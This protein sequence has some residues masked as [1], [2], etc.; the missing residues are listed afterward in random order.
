MER[1]FDRSFACSFLIFDHL[2]VP[3]TT[4]IDFKVQSFLFTFKIRYQYVI[5]IGFEHLLIKRRNIA[6]ALFTSILC[7]SISC[8]KKEEPIQNNV[9]DE[10][11]VTTIS[12][13]LQSIYFVS[14]NGAEL[15]VYN[16][17]S[18]NA[19]F[20]R[21]LSS[22]YGGIFTD[23]RN[24][25][26][27]LSGLSDDLIVY[28]TSFIEQW[29]VISKNT[30]FPFFHQFEEGL[31]EYFNLYVSNEDAEIRSYSSTGVTNDLIQIS[32]TN[33]YPYGFGNVSSGYSFVDVKDYSKSKE[34][35]HVY[36]TSTGFFRFKHD[37]KDKELMAVGD[38]GSF[39][40]NALLFINDTG[41]GKVL[42]SNIDTY[43]SNEFKILGVEIVD[44]VSLN[45]NEFVVATLNSGIGIYNYSN[46]TFGVF[47]STLND[48]K[49]LVNKEDNRVVASSEGTIYFLDD[50]GN[51][52]GSYAHSVPILGFSIMYE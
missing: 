40:K 46:N 47:N 33:M 49:L 20:K 10:E 26:L 28:D 4:K 2:Y 5:T 37:F 22:D 1:F 24:Q 11:V 45:S 43:V 29:R 39:S 23:S 13:V 50:S 17:K 51:V 25:H 18:G 30:S 9:P 27:I 31:G 44:V 8:K 38:V 7:F 3:Y 41:V 35:L 48:A 52:A 19:V 12:N 6:L 36:Y 15:D 34:E 42:V 16:Y 21:T 32:E 14:E